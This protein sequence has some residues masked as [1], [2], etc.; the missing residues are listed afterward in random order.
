MAVKAQEELKNARKS[1]NDAYEEAQIG[2]FN[3]MKEME[4]KTSK[5]MVYHEEDDFDLS[6]KKGKEKV[7]IIP[8]LSEMWNLFLSIQENQE[9]LTTEFKQLKEKE[10]LSEEKMQEMEDKVNEMDRDMKTIGFTQAKE[11]VYEAAVL[12]HH[13]GVDDI[14][15]D[16]ETGVEMVRRSLLNTAHN[17]QQSVEQDIQES[18]NLSNSNLMENYNQAVNSQ[19]NILDPILPEDN[20]ANIKH[21]VSSI[22]QEIGD[23]QDAIKGSKPNYGLASVFS[24]FKK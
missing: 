16:T 24:M 8:S 23:L 18:L 22:K 1:L 12:M 17:V 7:G 19:T 15:T 6:S 9:K 2:L 5:D 13:T 21:E 14:I 20:K 10:I 3:Q 11:A 4:Q